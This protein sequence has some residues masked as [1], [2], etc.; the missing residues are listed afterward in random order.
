MKRKLKT[1]QKILEENPDAHYREEG[2]LRLTSRN[3]TIGCSGFQYLGKT[4]TEG[5]EAHWSEY[6]LEPLPE[7]RKL[8]AYRISPSKIWY[9]T[10]DCMGTRAP[11]YDLNFNQDNNNEQN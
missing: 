1:I 5:T 9:G 8:Y 10:Q 2:S 6:L 7:P 11:E 3:I 4:V